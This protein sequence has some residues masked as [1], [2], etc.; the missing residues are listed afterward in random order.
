MQVEKG[1]GCEIELGNKKRKF[2]L[3]VFFDPLEIWVDLSGLPNDATLCALCD[4]ISFIEGKVGSK[5]QYTRRFVNI[6]W[7]INQWGGDKEIVE[8]VKKR[9]QKIIED[10]PNLME[11]Y[12]NSTTSKPT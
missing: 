8:A 6:E 3:K 4:G 2:F 5:G 12:G 1:N 11:K 7:I 9:K 10:I